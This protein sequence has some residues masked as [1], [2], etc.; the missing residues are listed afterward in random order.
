M[1][2]TIVHR[3]DRVKLTIPASTRRPAPAG[4]PEQRYGPV[5]RI[6]D[7][8]VPKKQPELLFPTVNFDGEAWNILDIRKRT[9][10]K[11]LRAIF[12][13]IIFSPRTAFG[14]TGHSR[15][16][17]FTA[18]PDTGF[19]TLQNLRL[20]VPLRLLAED[21]RTDYFG[22]LITVDQFDGNLLISIGML[23]TGGFPQDVLRSYDV[24]D[25]SVIALLD[26]AQLQTEF[27][28]SQI[29]V[30]AMALL[31]GSAY[32][33]NNTEPRN[34]ASYTVSPT[35]SQDS[36]QQ[37]IPDFDDVFCNQDG[38][39]NDVIVG[40]G[41]LY[42]LRKTQQLGT[43]TSGTGTPADCL[44]CANSLRFHD[45][46]AACVF[47]CITCVIGQV[48]DTLCSDCAECVSNCS[49]DCGGVCTDC[50]DKILA[51]AA[52]VSCAADQFSE[53]Q[54]AVFSL[55]AVTLINTVTVITNPFDTITS[56]YSFATRQSAINKNKTRLYFQMLSNDFIVADTLIESFQR[57]YC[58]D[59]ETDPENPAELG[60]IDITEPDFAVNLDAMHATNDGYLYV[61]VAGVPDPHIR[62]YNC[63][64]GTP[65]LVQDFDGT[66]LEASGNISE[67]V[68][69]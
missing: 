10:I 68:A 62:V 26:T 41:V 13:G 4:R 43:E 5:R 52:E 33:V 51:C 42:V 2:K 24:S 61:G 55:P 69:R 22:G 54:I 44:A 7:D 11:I 36:A 30:T 35:I 58:Y 50:A 1:A 31:G 46:C 65:V 45:E 59:I 32:I 27:A 38:A 14:T 57:I 66:N 25:S 28:A 15:V 60:F 12:D 39:L 49:S 20:A 53:L 63:K 29:D 48:E 18:G 8:D 3:G 16:S 21:T 34:L 19:T 9:A 40:D 6:E 56:R 37:L 23:I 67:F 47:T 17:V 64:T